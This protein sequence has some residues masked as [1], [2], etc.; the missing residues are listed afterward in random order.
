MRGFTLIELILVV[1]ILLVITGVAA[2]FFSRFLL[3]NDTALIS[4]QIAGQLRKAQIYSIS[5]RFNYPW[6][7]YKNGNDLILFAGSNF[8][9]ANPRFSETFS[10]NPNITIT[11]LNE[12]VFTRPNGIPS[13]ILTITVS[14]PVNSSKTITVNA[15]G[16]VQSL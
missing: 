10:L 13:T 12:I 14:S 1:V 11:G 9:S 7:L 4:D 15:Q 8:S 5:G 6:G 16:M 2:P 3:Q